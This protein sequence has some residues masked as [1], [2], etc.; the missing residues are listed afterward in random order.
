[1]KILDRF[2]KYIS[3]DTTS[4]VSSE[5]V[6]STK[7]QFALASLLKE[8]LTTLGLDVIYDANKCYLYATL[9]GDPDLPKIG[10]ISHMDTSE[11]CS[12]ASIKPNII[13]NYS[14]STINL[15]NNT[16]L[17]AKIYPDLKKHIGKT[18]I[19]TDGTTLLGSDDK[20]GI[21]EIM[22]MLEH[23]S[24]TKS[25]HGDIIVA[26]T[27]DEEIGRSITNFNI[28]LFPAKYAYTVDGSDLGELAYENFNAA[29]VDIDIAGFSTHTGDAKD[30][31]VN[32]ILIGNELLSFL[33]KEA[34]PE[35][36]DGYKGFI[37]VDKITGTVEH[38][39]IR[40]LIRDFFMESYTAKKNL[41][42]E[43]VDKLNEKY[44][45]RITMKIIDLFPNMKNVVEKNYEVVE[46]AERAIKSLGLEPLTTPIR[47]GTDGAE[48]SAL[49]LACPNLGTG[50]HNFHSPAEYVTLEDMEKTAD[51]LIAIVNESISE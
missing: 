43:I 35:T 17:D 20:A 22:T 1:M 39:T 37:H 26:F 16:I 2:L 9:K 15:K 40:L 27:P 41:L 21:A 25:R 47:G 28:S 4:S 48:L 6:P 24:K 7:K 11:A 14:G 46:I 33:P 30:L 13:H 29:S 44:Q 49:G 12:G 8:E 5:S 18:L 10:F 45:N 31:M 50:G 32:S 3:I 23:F 42:T 38:T 51:I 19:T 36:T 34:R